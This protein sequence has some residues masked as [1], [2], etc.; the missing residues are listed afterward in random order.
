MASII[1]EKGNNERW[2]NSAGD[3]ASISASIATKTTELNNAT[4]LLNE[5]LNGI[6]LC[7]NRAIGCVNKSGR[8]ISTW[9]DQRDKNAPL[10]TKY[11]SELAELLALQKDLT[12]TQTQSAQ[13]TQVI[14]DAETAVMKAE[15]AATIAKSTKLGLYLGIGA[16]VIALIIGG[17]YLFKKFKK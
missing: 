12:S 17:I 13:S 4:A 1:G 16:G 2:Y 5:A 11:K 3:L 14:A 8:H 10:V 9:R 15:T 6:A 7:D